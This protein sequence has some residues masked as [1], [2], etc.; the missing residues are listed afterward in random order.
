MEDLQVIFGGLVQ[1]KNKEDLKNFLNDM[2][3]SQAFA[4][5]EQALLFSQKQGLFS[6]EESNVVYK[7]IS[8]L[9]ENEETNLP[10]NLPDGNSDGSVN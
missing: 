4:L 3:K 10:V 1:F 5:I 6:F 9:K 7:S 8:K 2:E